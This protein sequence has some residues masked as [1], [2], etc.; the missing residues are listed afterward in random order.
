MIPIMVGRPSHSTRFPGHAARPNLEAHGPS[1][2]HEAPRAQISQIFGQFQYPT[3]PSA[4]V[5]HL[6]LESILAAADDTDDSRPEIEDLDGVLS[7]L[8]RES[9]LI[10]DVDVLVDAL[11]VV[12]R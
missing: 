4:P 9:A 10:Q 11:P 3:P 7:R 12:G 2:H 8:A 1:H 6:R 5:S